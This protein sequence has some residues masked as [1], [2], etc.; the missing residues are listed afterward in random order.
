MNTENYSNNFQNKI[1]I[2]NYISPKG[3]L[4]R[5]YRNPQNKESFLNLFKKKQT[6]II[7]RPDFFSMGLKNN[8]INKTSKS[9]QFLSSNTSN[10]HDRK[11]IEILTPLKLNNKIEYDYRDSK[12]FEKTKEKKYLDIFEISE[13]DKIFNELQRFTKAKLQK[14]NQ[15]K[16]NV[17]IK[18]KQNKSY[19]TRYNTNTS[20]NQTLNKIY[21][22]NKE[23]MK[24]LEKSKKLK[25]SLSLQKY[26]KLLLK[27]GSKNLDIPTKIKL[28][29]TFLSLRKSPKRKMNILESLVTFENLEKKIINSINSKQFLYQK[30]IKEINSLSSSRP[31]FGGLKTLPKIKFHQFSILS[32]NKM[33][34]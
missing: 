11:N 14:S 10:N 32:P 7:K 30:K 34:N 20:K 18:K 26:Q 15:N 29:K 1:N 12:I 33:T 3:N 2:N 13:N 6:N 31:A 27:V 16:K 22:T 25:D 21:K 4:T 8:K 24:K 28:E 17:E 19:N 23:I 5:L 9:L